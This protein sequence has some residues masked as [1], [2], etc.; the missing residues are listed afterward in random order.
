[1][2]RARAGGSP[3]APVPEPGVTELGSV[4]RWTS[5]EVAAAAGEEKEDGAVARKNLRRS[6]WVRRDSSRWE[7]GRVSWPNCDDDLDYR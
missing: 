2:K 4:M 3:L 1:M 5:A 7:R 6:R